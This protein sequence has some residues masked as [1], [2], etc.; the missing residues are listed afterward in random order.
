MM[1]VRSRLVMMIIFH[2]TIC[3]YF[4]L[5]RVVFRYGF[6]LNNN[7]ST[8][9]VSEDN[10]QT[11][12]VTTTEAG[13]TESNLVWNKYRQSYTSKDILSKDENWSSVNH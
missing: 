8:K 2:K 9:L 5:E 13:T 4:Y 3:W 11:T 1:M 7:R 12:V 6:Y 10:V